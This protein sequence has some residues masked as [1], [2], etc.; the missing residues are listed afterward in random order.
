MKQYRKGDFSAFTKLYKILS[1]K[2]YGYLRRRGVGA[3]EI[4]DVFQQVFL[5][6]HRYR[7]R[8]DDKHPVEAWVFT[9]TRSVM[10]DHFKKKQSKPSWEPLYESKIVDSSQKM[11]A[12]PIS[13]EGLNNLDKELVTKRYYNDESFSDIAKDLG[14]TSQNVRKRLSRSIRK[15]RTKWK[16]SHP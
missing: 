11:P 10:L 9:I 5:K 16:R 15:L 7:E 1:P 12:D 4:D 6:F 8:Y 13:L 3:S 2:I 14:L